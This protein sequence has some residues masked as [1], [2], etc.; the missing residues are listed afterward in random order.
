MVVR[1]LRTY[2]AGGNMAFVRFVVGEETVVCACFVL[3]QDTL[4]CS[5][6][7]LR[8][9]VCFVACWENMAFVRFM[10]GEETLLCVCFVLGQ[11]TLSY[12]LIHAREVWEEVEADRTANSCWR[13]WFYVCFMGDVRMVVRMYD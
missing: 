6:S 10:W 9:Y 7:D 11:H 8:L 5:G 4:V 2:L 3:G 1:R 13:G 12:A